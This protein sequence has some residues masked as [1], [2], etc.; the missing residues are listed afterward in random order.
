MI[1][2]F[3]GCLNYSESFIPNLSKKRAI[4]QRLL[5]KKNTKG[6]TVEHTEAVKK[7]KEECKNLPK[8]R[9]PDET[10]RDAQHTY[11]TQAHVSFK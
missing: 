10:D 2:K 4:L 3:L 9:L 8:L 6:W 1:Q 5:K 11:F 7:L